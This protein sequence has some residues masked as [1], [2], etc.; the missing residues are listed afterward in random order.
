MKP[1]AIVLIISSIIF[2]NS[3]KKKQYYEDS[4]TTF[5]T[6]Y[7]IKYEASELLTD[8]IDNEIAKFN[9]SLNPFNANSIIAKVNNNED[10]EVDS[11]FT[12]VFNKS[13]EVY[14]KSGGTFDPTVAPLIN[15]WGFGFE[16]SDSISPQIID[17]LLNYVGFNKIRIENKRVIKDNPAIKLNFSAIAK[18]YA[19]DIIGDLLESEGVKNYLVDIGREVK[20][21]GKNKNGECWKIGIEKPESPSAVVTDE[22]EKVIQLCKKRGIA[23]SGDYRNYYIKDGKKYAHTIDPA[24]GYPSGNGIVSATIVA[25]DC[26]TA[27]AYATAFM[28]LGIDKAQK[29]AETLPDTEYFIIYIDSISNEYK[30]V[31]SKWN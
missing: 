21:K 4:G 1:T 24:T 16:K 9:L 15:L 6:L 19:C 13:K 14:E 23:T 18:G 2:C 7:H 29:L 8:K 25:P 12:T 31:S 5:H 30:S 26:I 3:C 10:V 22:V 20:S 17:S 11:F 28:V 27:D